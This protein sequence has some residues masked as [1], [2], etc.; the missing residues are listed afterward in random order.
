MLSLFVTLYIFLHLTAMTSCLLGR[1]GWA[2]AVCIFWFQCH[3]VVLSLREPMS[4]HWEHAKFCVEVFYAL[5][6]NFHSLFKSRGHTVHLS[7]AMYG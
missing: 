5:Y 3:L 2:E 4:M 1:G 6:I 7:C